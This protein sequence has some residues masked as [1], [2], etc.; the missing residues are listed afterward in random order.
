M[1][2]VIVAA[3]SVGACLASGPAFSAQPGATEIVA[4]AL[5]NWTT[6]FTDDRE[7]GPAGR[8]PYFILEPGFTLELEGTEDGAKTRTVVTVLPETKV[9]AGITAAVVEERGTKGGELEE[10]TKDYY[11]ISKRT[12]SVYYLGEDVDEYR[13]GKIIGHGSAWLTGVKGAAYGLI[14]PGLPLV[15][16]RYYQEQ[17]PEVGMD[18]AEVSSVT[19]VVKTPAGTFTGCLRTE[20]S[21]AMEPG[22][23]S[24]K[25]YAPG[26]GMIQDGSLLLVKYGFAKK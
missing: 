2:I 14:M 13:H 15:G 7:L 5:E 17:A 26:I 16:A 19:D 3:V 25:A 4:S 9:I 18:R 21:N 6:V 24:I 8:N 20:E 22:Q 1:K 11:A 12:N 23:T 10:V